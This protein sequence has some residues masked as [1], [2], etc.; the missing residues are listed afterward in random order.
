MS[1]LKNFKL[2]LIC[3][4]AFI[5]DMRERCSIK[6]TVDPSKLPPAS[7]KDDLHQ[8]L[9]CR[10]DFEGLLLFHSLVRPP[11]LQATDAAERAIQLQQVLDQLRNV[12]P[13]L[14][15]E[16]QQL[17]ARFSHLLAESL[18]NC[19]KHDQSLQLLAAQRAFTRTGNEVDIAWIQL[20]LILSGQEYLQTDQTR[21][22]LE[23]FQ[24]FTATDEWRGAHECLWAI[25]KIYRRNEK[26][27]QYGCL[28]ASRLHIP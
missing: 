16:K 26:F 18:R 21:R 5:Q 3:L 14:S 22:L 17:E 12:S 25:A 23:L 8:D 15:M 7:I 13:V 11:A 28:L 24:R 27:I 2:Y 10:D 1:P 9:L 19:G 6:S 20:E 4:Y